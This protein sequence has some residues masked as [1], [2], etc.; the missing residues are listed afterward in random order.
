MKST[1][2]LNFIIGSPITYKVAVVNRK[3]VPDKISLSGRLGREISK[4]IEK[5]FFYKPQELKKS[6]FKTVNKKQLENR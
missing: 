6:F 2:M 1:K 3:E 5:Q 4:V